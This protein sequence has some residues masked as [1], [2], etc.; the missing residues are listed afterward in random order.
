[1]AAVVA[2]LIGKQH[3]IVYLDFVKDI[4][5]IA[6]ALREKCV[7]TCSYHGKNMSSHDKVKAMDHWRPD[8]SA[9]Q[10]ST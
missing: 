5:P 1:M 9:V 10:V 4:A 8:D 3:G 2:D 7:S 6:N